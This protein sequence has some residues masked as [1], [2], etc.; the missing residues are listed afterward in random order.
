MSRDNFTKQT[1]DIL[2]KRVGFYCSN[3]SCRKHTVGP[4][5]IEDKAILVGVAAHITAASPG[6]PRYDEILNFSERTHINNGIWLCCNCATLIDKDD[7]A[8]P[9]TL[10]KKWKEDAELEM[11]NKIYGELEKTKGNNQFPFLEADLIWIRATRANVGYSDK[12]RE[13]FGGNVIPPGG[14]P[15]IYWELTWYFSFIL[16][17]N[18][19]YPAYNISIEEIGKT[20]FSRLSKLHNINNLPPFANIDLEAECSQFIEGEHTVAD[21]LMKRKIPQIIDGLEL[22]IKY[23]DEGR[24]LHS[25]LI[26]INNQEI[27]NFKLVNN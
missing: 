6:G 10:L 20:K 12:T 11:R 22:I 3:P 13:K 27:N 24:N 21:E 23:F 8:F 19:S 1:I 25:T 5:D 26:K 14:K 16:H 9:A 18:S 4:N 7:I 15:I 2:A 17:N